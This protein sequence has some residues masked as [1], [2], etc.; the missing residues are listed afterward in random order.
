MLC[1]YGILWRCGAAGQGRA[2]Q[3]EARVRRGIGGRGCLGCVSVCV[4]V[5]LWVWLWV[6]AREGDA[7]CA[8]SADGMVWDGA[9]IG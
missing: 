2:E 1:G 5:W 6:W 3:G 4:W 9:W 7:W 8:S